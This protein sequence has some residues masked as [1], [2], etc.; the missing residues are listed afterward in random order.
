MLLVHFI[1]MYIIIIS[2][3]IV[4]EKYKNVIVKLER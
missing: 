2:K 1:I 3:Q 4:I